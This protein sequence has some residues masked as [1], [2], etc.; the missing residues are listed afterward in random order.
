MKGYIALDIGGTKILGVFFNENKEEI[1]REKKST[2]AHKGFEKVQEKICK[3]IDKL[4][5]DNEI[6]AIG[7]GIPGFVRDGIVEFTPNLPLTGFNIEKFL[8]EKY[9]VPVF[10]GNDANVSLYGEY[11]HGAV[12]D[13]KNIAG[14]FVGT[15]VGG[16]III[17]GK[18]YTG[19]IGGAGEFGHMTIDA[20]GP[21]CGC[22]SRGCVEAVASKTSMHRDF[23]NSIK[24]G[25]ETSMKEHIE[26]K[27]ILKSSEL[28]EAYET[29]DDVTLHI[30]DNMIHNLGVASGSIMNVL[31]P[32]VIVF[33]GGIMESMGNNLLPEII[34]VSEY[35]SIPQIFQN[36]KFKIAELGDDA[37]IY[38]ALGLIED[39][40]EEVD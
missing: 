4:S 30:V 3:V 9:D 22:G 35:F 19:S 7:L 21:Y 8:K 18:M 29:K 25:F 17:N 27:N 20:H 26:E 15:G 5:E 24:K 2:K 14:F 13:F 32:E 12:K 1:R 39:G 16:G 28:K 33:G 11:K 34:R 38:G 37:C 40:L 36:T 10:V 31:N 23:K 6:L